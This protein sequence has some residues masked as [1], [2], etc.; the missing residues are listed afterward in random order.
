[1][2]IEWAKDGLD[3]RI[4]VVQAR[5]ETVKSRDTRVIERYR[6]R[7]RGEVLAEGRA[8][9]QKI[10]SGAARLI[11]DVERMAELQPGE[12]L[13]TDMTDPDWEPVM[14]RAGAIVTNRGGRTCHAAIIARELGIPAVVG[15]GDATHELRGPPGGHGELRR[16]GRGFHLPRGARLRRGAHRPRFHARAPSLGDDERGESREGLPVRFPPARG[17]R[18][19]PA[20][21]RDRQQHRDSSRGR[22]SSSRAFPGSCKRPSPSA[23]GAIA[24]R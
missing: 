15:C 20:G 24:T 11:R 3:G 13:V 21:V 4:Y 7:A 18:P 5:P 19:R 16:G 6:L 2:D 22:F 1:M 14:K 17:R 23:S 10:A 12:I 9:G 8:V